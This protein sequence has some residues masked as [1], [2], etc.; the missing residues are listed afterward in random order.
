MRKARRDS[1]SPDSAGIGRRDSR[2]RLSPDRQGDRELSPG[3]RSRR[4][5]LRR[6]S[7][8]VAGRHGHRSP[9]SSSCSSRDPS[10]CNRPPGPPP[11]S[12]N[13][14]PAASD[15]C[16]RYRG[17]RDSATQILDGTIASMTVE[18]SST[19]FDSS[20]QTG[21]GVDRS[22]TRF[23]GDQRQRPRRLHKI[24]ALKALHVQLHDHRSRFHNRKMR[25]SHPCLAHLQSHL[26]CT[27]TI[28]TTRNACGATPAGST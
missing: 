6:Q 25:T 18:T 17:R 13:Y 4:G 12:E 19:F 23:A 24:A 21:K 2:S 26:L 16:Q 7:T 14:R 10:P 9:E 3:R 11:T 15:D 28:T 8:S 22:A 27:T 5:T 20:T 1:L